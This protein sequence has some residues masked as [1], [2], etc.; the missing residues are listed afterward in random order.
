MSLSYDDYV[1]IVKSTHLPHATRMNALNEIL[2]CPA[3]GALKQLVL[4][5]RFINVVTSEIH[6]Y[7][8]SSK[9]LYALYRAFGLENW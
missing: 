8:G 3:P 6:E 9:L 4:D 5:E 2:H 7:Q 1:T